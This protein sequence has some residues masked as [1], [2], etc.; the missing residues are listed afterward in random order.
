MAIHSISSKLYPHAFRM[1]TPHSSYIL[2][3]AADGLAVHLYYGPKLSDTDMASVCGEENSPWFPEPYAEMLLDHVPLEYSASGKEDL[4]PSALSVL[5]DDGDNIADLR[6]RSHRIVTG[7]PSPKGLPHVYTEDDSEAQTLILALADAKGLEVDLYYT[8]L[9][10]FDAVIRRTVIRNAGTQNVSLLRVMSASEDLPENRM[11]M[12]SLN[13]SWAREC[14]VERQSVT[15]CRERIESFRGVSG[16]RHNPFAA[17]VSQDCTETAGETY[18]FSMVYSGNFCIETEVDCHDHLRVNAGLSDRSFRWPLA[19]GESFDTPE[20]VLV[21]SNRGLGGMSQAYHQLYAKRVSRGYWR[22]RPRPVLLNTWEGLYFDFNHEKLIR[23]A[24]SAADIGIELFVLDDGWFGH[25]SN[26][27]SSLGDWVPWEEK[28]GCTLPQLVSE[29][30]SLGLAF[31]IWVEPEMISEDSNLYHAHPDW[32][33]CR[34]ARTATQSRTQLMLD[35]TRPEVCDYIIDTMTKLFSSANISYVKWDMNRFMTEVGSSTDPKASAGALAHRYMLSVYRMMDTLTSRFPKILFEGCAGGGGRFDP[36]TL[37]YF[38]QVWTSDDTDPVQRLTIQGGASLAYPTS[39][40]SCHVSASPNHQLG[41]LTTFETRWN[42][43][44]L[45][46]GFGYELDTTKLTPD[47]RETVRQQIIQYKKERGIL[48]GSELYRLAAPKDTVAFQQISKDKRHIVV[49][50][51]RKLFDMVQETSWLHLVDLES[52]AIY[53][54]LE[55]GSA[56]TGA[57]L[58]GMGV[59][60]HLPFQDFASCRIRFERI[61]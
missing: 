58:M 17:V 61:N 48:F 50:C 57:A 53:R 16:H 45:G 44:V 14:H 47:E 56:C 33:L 31:G 26:A 19:P 18:G 29:I 6:Y 37:Y 5:W 32:V 55:T 46:G 4:R 40:M 3:I 30:N 9:E 60:L 43:A 21:Y 52:A 13:G 49:T 7:K 59:R 28:L 2:G 39:M 27:N 12:I 54:N 42:I 51:C 41:R 1:D 11:D 38:P 25:R 23:L 10:H 34:P 22:D 35:L 8:V 24:K 20:A 36:G 15:H